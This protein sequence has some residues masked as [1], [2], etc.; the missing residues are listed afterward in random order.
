MCDSTVRLTFHEDETDPTERPTRDCRSQRQPPPRQKPLMKLQAFSSTAIMPRWLLYTR[1]H[2]WRTHD[3]TIQK[4]WCLLRGCSD[5]IDIYWHTRIKH[6]QNDV[7]NVEFCFPFSFR[8]LVTIRVSLMSVWISLGSVPWEDCWRPPCMERILTWKRN[9]DSK[10][11]MHTTKTR[12]KQSSIYCWKQ[13]NIWI[14]ICSDLRNPDIY[15]LVGVEH[16]FRTAPTK[17]KTET[18]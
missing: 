8:L 6:M 3:I 1:D 7:P 2:S 12:W 9:F 4:P 5:H 11:S 10:T 17:L 13:I 14:S 18:S 16:P 15:L